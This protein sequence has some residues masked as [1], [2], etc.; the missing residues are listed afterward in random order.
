MAKILWLSRHK[1]L[2]SQLRELKR[3]F[4]E[5]TEI[6]QDPNPFSGAD[7]IIA[8][9]REG[10]YNELVAVAPLSVI[11]QLTQRGIKPLWAEM[12]QVPIEEAEVVATGR[13]YRFMQFKR[14]KRVAMEFEEL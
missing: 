6:I 9:F 1:P 8:R 2:P 7:E 12:K 4:G 13:G 5:H 14:I 3:V 11:A 10:G